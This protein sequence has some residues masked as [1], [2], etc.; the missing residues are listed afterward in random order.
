M[1]EAVVSTGWAVERHGRGTH[2]R[3]KA[4]LLGRVRGG[5]AGRRRNLLRMRAPALRGWG[6]SGIGCRGRREKSF[7]LATGEQG[8]LVQAPGAGNLLCGLRAALG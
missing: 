2:R 5:G 1:G 3:S 7:S 4:P 8:L 6:V